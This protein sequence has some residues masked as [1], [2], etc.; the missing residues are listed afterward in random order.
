MASLRRNLVRNAGR[1]WRNS[2]KAR[3][4]ETVVER[5]KIICDAKGE[6]KGLIAK[7]STEGSDHWAYYPK[8][9]HVEAFAE[10]VKLLRK[11]GPAEIFPGSVGSIEVIKDF[12][13][14]QIKHMQAHFFVG[15]GSSVNRAL[16]TK[17]GGWR[18]RLLAEIF[19]EVKKTK[20]GVA[21]QKN[22]LD[23]SSSSKERKSEMERRKIFKEVATKSGL[24]VK[25]TDST[26]I[27]KK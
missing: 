9:E 15:R 12:G 11:S 14:W 1:L 26:I 3:V 2:G 5:H 25:E 22:Q 24:T 6:P 16:A 23:S 19:E 21:Y 8:E 7:T 18:H 20:R 10:A 4:F 17:Y 13:I 27:A